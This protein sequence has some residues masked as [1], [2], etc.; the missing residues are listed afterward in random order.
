MDVKA[1]HLLPGG[2]LL[3]FL[4]TEIFNFSERQQLFN[5]IFCPFSA[6]ITVNQEDERRN[7]KL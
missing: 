7:L 6:D 4:T 5:N 3:D 1:E 2:M